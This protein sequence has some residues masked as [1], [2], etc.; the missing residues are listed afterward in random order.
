[1]GMRADAL[2]AA[3][4]VITEVEKIAVDAGEYC[5]ATVG[6]L[7]VY[8]NGA[9]VIPDKIIFTVDIRSKSKQSLDDMI[10][11]VKKVIHLEEKDGLTVKE[12]LTLYVEPTEL[13]TRIVNKFREHSQALGISEIPMVSGAGHDAMIFA[14][15]TDVGLI[16][17]PS[18]D[19]MSHHPSEWTE[20]DEIA[21]GVSVLFETVK[22]LTETKDVTQ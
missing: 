10:S 15:I 5:V 18:K 2:L 16:F 11:A 13:S 21:K 4:R 20:Y 6:R 8:P 22:E 7:N 1:M 9:N 19:G 17:V 12:A 14:N 3:S